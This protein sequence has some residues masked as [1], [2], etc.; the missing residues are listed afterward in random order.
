MIIIKSHNEAI[1]FINNNQG[2]WNVILFTNPDDPFYRSDLN[3]LITHSKNSLV[4][5]F[6]DLEFP[7]EGYQL[8][9]KHHV[10]EMLKWAEDKDDIVCS[11]HAGVSRS[12]AAAYL[13]Q[14]KKDPQKALEVLDRDRHFPN[15]ILIKLGAEVLNRHEIVNSLNEWRLN[16]L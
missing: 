13:I 16:G 12:S 9:E 1:R 11:C 14:C 15:P 4:L 6:Y 2:K 3:D 5:K 8:P 10:E 7:R